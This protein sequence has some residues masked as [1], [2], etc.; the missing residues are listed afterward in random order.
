MN[1]GAAWVVVLSA[2]LWAVLPFGCGGPASSAAVP[3]GASGGSGGG[4]P[5]PGP[6]PGS[7]ISCTQ[8][9]DCQD[10]CSETDDACFDA[11]EARGMASARASYAALVGCW[12]TAGCQDYECVE[13][14]CASQLQACDG[15]VPGTD[16]RPPTYVN[17]GAGGTPPANGGGGSGPAPIT[18]PGVL[19]C[20][21][22]WTCVDACADQSCQDACVAGA[23]A[24]AVD[25]LVG[26]ASCSK[27]NNCADQACV[28]GKCRE[29]VE[30]CLGSLGTGGSGGGGGS[31]GQGGGPGPGV[32][33]GGGEEGWAPVEAVNVNDVVRAYEGNSVGADQRFKGKRIQVTGMVD[34]IKPYDYSPYAG[35]IVVVFATAFSL[36]AHVR[37]YFRQAYA[38]QLGRIAPGTEIALNGTVDRFDGITEVALGHCSLP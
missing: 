4:S 38:P 12:D 32:D 26:V 17:G 9:L 1:R 20:G 36:N 16:G 24:G 3:G 11:C 2:S 8:I 37:C 15:M 14:H 21:A 13:A 18:S 10:S 35:Q 29:Q 30:A 33:P 28:V 25:A 23:Q 34:F 7:G 6:G 31:G 19:D 22:L 27:A 5:G